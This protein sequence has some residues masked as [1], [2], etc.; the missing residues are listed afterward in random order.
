MSLT[1]LTISGFRNLTDIKLTPLPVGLNFFY[2]DNGSG[3]T[4]LLES[5]YYLI[6]GRSFRTP[7][8]NH[9]IQHKADQFSIFAQIA[10]QTPP[11]LPAGVEKWRN[12]RTTLKINGEETSSFT[13]LATTVPTLL[14]HAGSHHLLDAGP[15]F[16]RKYLDWGAFYLSPRFFAIWKQYA[17][18]LRQRNTLLRQKQRHTEEL[19][20]W[21]AET[22]K[23]GIE[24][25]DER[26][27]FVAKLTPFLEKTLEKLGLFREL[28]LAYSPGWKAG[29]SLQ[30]AMESTQEKDLHI[31]HTH[32]GPHR[33]DFTIEMNGIS[34]K[35][36]LSRGQ[37]KLAVYAM[38]VAQGALLKHHYAR[39]PIYLADDLSAELD[40]LSR[41]RIMDLLLAQ[42]TQVFLTATGQEALGKLKQHVPTKMFHVEH[43]S[44]RETG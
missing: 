30:Q 17:R 10:G 37:Q 4:S 25:D 5:I 34:A 6:Y 24:L 31:G 29:M 7:C 1:T 16:R 8:I 35:E 15:I 9:V 27:Q 13:R 28:Q 43:G 38:L 26:Q 33:A 3:K 14:I 22:I 2:G 32:C 19:A 23:S 20:V 12:G 41:T 42:N 40:P 21:T 18:A 39:N 11:I 36:R 44:I